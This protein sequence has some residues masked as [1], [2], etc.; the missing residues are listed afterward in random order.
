[1]RAHLKM[2]RR[3]FVILAM[4][5]TAAVSLPLTQCGSDGNTD[6]PELLYTLIGKS[7][8]L[9]I[10]KAYVERFP[11]ESDR[12]KLTALISATLNEQPASPDN[13]RIQNEFRNGKVVIIN[14]WILSLTEARQSALHYLNS[15]S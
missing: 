3:R 8:T 14:G 5:G 1:L 7:K 15:L 13:V 9:E 4:A 2:K 11:S 12:N 6:R 10:G